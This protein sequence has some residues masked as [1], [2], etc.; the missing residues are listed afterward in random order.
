MSLTDHKPA[1]IFVHGF[2]SSA[3][4]WD[5]LINLLKQ[6]TAV[7]S[8]FEFFRFTYSTKALEIKPHD[9]IPRIGE[10][11]K[12]L[13]EF[14][15]SRQFYD[16]EIV[17][18]G[19]SLGG[20]VIQNY[21]A[22]M[23]KNGYGERLSPIRQVITMA[24]PSLGSTFLSPG[25]KLFGR[26][27]PNPQE[28]S[29]RVLDPSTS[30]TL[31]FVAEHVVQAKKGTNN[32]WPIP[33]HVFYGT[34]DNIVLQ[35][36]AHGVFLEENVTPV[37][38]D[39]FTIL[40]PTDHKDPL[41]TKFV[42][43]LLDPSGHSS[44]YEVDLYETEVSV[45]PVDKQDFPRTRAANG[46]TVRTDNIGCIDRSVVFSHKNRC[47]N[48]F[49]IP[50]RTRHDGYL[51]PTYFPARTNEA[52][53]YEISEYDDYGVSSVFKF[54]P[55]P[56]ET[57]RSK[58]DVYDGFSEGQRNIHFHMGRSSYSKQ[59]VYLLDLT[60]YLAAGFEITKEP[61]LHFHPHDPGDHDLCQ[62]RGSGA[63]VAPTLVDPRGIWRW[64]LF[65]IR[66]G[67]VDMV[68]DLQQK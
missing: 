8:Q 68:W 59:R 58:V 66:Q 47:T 63:V 27:F 46:G 16:R 52:S 53:E 60:A 5:T 42:D 18:V 26:F 34:Q 4:T 25:R 51:D 7:D 49:E 62:A 36:S 1:V 21:L 32:Q 67:V 10:V 13:R 15:D 35:E 9:R 64:E 39:H 43:A 44:V 17:L 56:G 6:D 24:T 2:L 22:Y 31:S 40:T 30:D 23:L 54:T 38:A 50:Y 28:Q 29:L 3:E 12:G 19:H 65:R 45:R 55:K 41:Y 61:T 37:T 33:F 57:F 48:I 11:A 20:L 14:L